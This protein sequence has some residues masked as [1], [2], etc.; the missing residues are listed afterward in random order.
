M[1]HLFCIIALLFFHTQSHFSKANLYTAIPNGSEP[2]SEITPLL[3]E[4][5][6]YLGEGAQ[7]YAFVS[8]DGKTVLKLFKA[9]HQKSF[10][11]SRFFHT[12]TRGKEAKERSHLKWQHKFQ[13][14]CR[15]YK[16]AFID[17]KEETGLIHLHF[18]KTSTALL[19][20]LIDKT[21]HQID[22]SSYPFILQKKA[23]LA[24]DYIHQHPDKKELAIQALKDFFSNRMQ[25][26]FSDPRQSLSINYGFVNDRPIQ[27]DVGK[28]EPF[29]GDA[30]RELERIHTRIDE[31][32]SRL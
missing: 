25:K 22:L 10:K 31:W 19:V 29:K 14:T 27:I 12:L 15:R 1:K 2:T 23:I 17:L 32:V 9:K 3:S 11:L 6:T 8:E 30:T 16:W 5:F 24:P 26:G 13:D 21:S 28:I 4:P 18:E 7:V 20:T